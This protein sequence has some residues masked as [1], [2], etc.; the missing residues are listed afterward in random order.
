MVRSLAPGQEAYRLVAPPTGELQQADIGTSTCNIE[1]AAAL[2]T[3]DAGIIPTSNR[4][5]E[6]ENYAAASRPSGDDIL[7]GSDVRV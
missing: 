5:D 7:N 2:R 1:R 3:D 6:G 4:H